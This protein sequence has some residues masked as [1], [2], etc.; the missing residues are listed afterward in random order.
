MIKYSCT[1][2]LGHSMSYVHFCLLLCTLVV[3]MIHFSARHSVFSWYTECYTVM[4]FNIGTLD[5]LRT[6]LFAPLYTGGTNDSFPC[7]SLCVQ[8]IHTMLH[9]NCKYRSNEAPRQNYV[10][11]NPTYNFTQRNERSGIRINV[12][13]LSNPTWLSVTLPTLQLIL[14]PFFRLSYV[15]GFSLMS[16]GEPPMCLCLWDFHCHF[17]PSLPELRKNIKKIFFSM[18][19]CLEWEE[20][21]IYIWFFPKSFI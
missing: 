20:K 11:K 14:Q 15:T 7:T 18:K 13:D 12:F 16:L 2:I 4:Y 9:C 8:L 5:E 3:L 19:S 1:L 10:W 21:Y 17:N 6:F